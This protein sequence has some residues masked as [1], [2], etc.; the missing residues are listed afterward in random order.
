M[1]GVFLC[2]GISKRMVPITKDKV[3]LDFLGKPLLQHQIE[4]AQGRGLNHFVLIGNRQNIDKLEQV[5][6]RIPYGRFEFFLQKQSLGM[7]DALKSAES[8]LRGPALVLSPNDVFSSLAYS[9]I[10]ES[11]EDADSYM[12]GCQVNEY[13]PGGYLEVDSRGYLKHIV[14]KPLPG[15]EPSNLVN[16]VVHLHNRPEKVLEYIHR[17]ESDSD[18]VYER[19][20]DNM[21]SDG[22]RIKVIPYSDFWGAI[23]YPWNILKVMDYFLDQAEPYVSPTARISDRA[24]VEGKVVLAENVR[25]LEHAVIRGP[26]YVGPNSIIGNNVLL[27]D[28][29]HI[30]S[31]CVIG[32]CTEVKHSYI[33][34]NCWFHSNYVGDSIIDDECSFGS[35]AITA[36]FRFD[37]ANVCVGTGDGKVDTGYDKL[38]AIVGKGCRLGINANLMPGVRVG[39]HSFVG[40]RVCL[41]KDLDANKM[42]LPVTQYEVWD[43]NTKLAQERRQELF[44]RL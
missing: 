37:E 38:G 7:A 14:E 23:K 1:K 25:V 36:N 34:D 3:L 12:L 10:E 27:R 17:V 28:H 39:S 29:S 18:D 5:T 4:M 30:G 35:G 22:Y 41:T 26:V 42:A 8:V 44:R 33:G 6:H 11:D 19:A 31:N 9:I 24:V 43:N 15:E 2:G 20:L 21:V 32:Y 40:P 13:F 16:M